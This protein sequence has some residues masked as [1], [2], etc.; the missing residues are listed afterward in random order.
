MNI[1]VEWVTNSIIIYCLCDFLC[2][3]FEFMRTGIIKI[4]KIKNKKMK[5]ECNVNQDCSASKRFALQDFF[6]L[7]INKKNDH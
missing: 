5:V 4:K 3:L 1:K 2:T 6:F 7:P